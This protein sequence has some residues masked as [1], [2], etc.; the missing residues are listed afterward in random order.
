MKNKTNV[1]G[2]K[3]KDIWDNL[4]NGLYKKGSIID[5]KSDYFD[6]SIDSL[7]LLKKKWARKSFSKKKSINLKKKRK[8]FLNFYIRKKRTLKYKQN[9]LK[10]L[11]TRCVKLKYRLAYK[12]TKKNLLKSK[13][14]SLWLKNNLNSSDKSR[15]LVKFFFRNKDY[16]NWGNFW[17]SKFVKNTIKKK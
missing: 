6:K 14:S 7:Y 8:P 10:F 12:L 1:R 15:L 13:I 3:F 4:Y 2:Y 11:L 5:K 9:D 16:V 17:K